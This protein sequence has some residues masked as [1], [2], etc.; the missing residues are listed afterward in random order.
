M[1]LAGK[2]ALL[3][4]ARVVA[5]SQGW[6]TIGIMILFTIQNGFLVMLAPED[7]RLAILVVARVR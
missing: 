7:K 6:N 2:P 4:V 5:Q 1:A 3:V